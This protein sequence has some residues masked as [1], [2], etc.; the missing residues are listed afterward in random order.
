[1]NPKPLPPK[2]HILCSYF[3][4]A[5]SECWCGLPTLWLGAA[6]TALILVGLLTL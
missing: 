3:Y 2:R 1:M 5:P 6:A 4:C